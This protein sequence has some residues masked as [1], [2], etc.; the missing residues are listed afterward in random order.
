MMPG[1]PPSAEPSVGAGFPEADNPAARKIGKALRAGRS[2]ADLAQESILRSIIADEYPSGRLPPED[3]LAAQLAVSRTTVRAALQA[4]ER[5]GLV[6][7]RQ[8]I[9]T[10][11][12]QHV[13]P[14][15]LG[16]QRLAG[17]EALLQE[18]GYRTEVQERTEYLPADAGLA[19]RLEIAVGA[20]CLVTSKTFLADGQPA[21]FVTDAI[22]TALLS[23]RPST[24]PVGSLYQL[25]EL[26]HTMRL[27]HSV[28]EL[29]PHIAGARDCEQLGLL[30][31]S[32]MLMLTESHY[33]FEGARMGTST[34]AINDRYMRF[35]VIRR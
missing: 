16:L 17:F 34:A 13:D 5:A 24:S 31:H 25:F 3:V 7:R 10:V 4:L 27:D 18:S 9:G 26:H 22:A 20:E 15:T 30:P 32:P 6:A 14:A 33:T 11:I 23:S 1:R 12:N 28:V 8:G 21:V 19:E 35:S 29:R 2:L